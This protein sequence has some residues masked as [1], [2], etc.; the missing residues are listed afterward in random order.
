[1]SKNTAWTVDVA[2]WQTRERISYLLVRIQPSALYF[3]TYNQMPMSIHLR[4]VPEYYAR[5]SRGTVHII[6]NRSFDGKHEMSACGFK[7]T[8]YERVTE[9][10]EGNICKRCKKILNDK[11]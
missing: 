10:Q 2:K 11:G 3:F 6:T 7:S 5:T 4:P 9:P 8:R 1:M